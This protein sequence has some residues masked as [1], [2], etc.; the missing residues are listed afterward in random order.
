MKSKQAKQLIR[1]ARKTAKENIQAS[2]IANLT[3]VIGK[4]GHGSK[5]L[6]R[7][8]V[9]GAKILA[10]KLAKDLVIDGGAV[11]AEQDKA[12]AA[13]TEQ[14]AA[15]AVAEKPKKAAAKKEAT[16]LPTVESPS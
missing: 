7:K 10:K 15:V 12:E 14:E 9:K 13:K 11:A 8:I 5:K 6:D 4:A 16:D 3:E 2:L 1:A